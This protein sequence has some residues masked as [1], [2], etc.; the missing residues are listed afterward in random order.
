MA[1]IVTTSPL[2]VS[3]VAEKFGVTPQAVRK[4]ITQG[5]RGSYLKASRA[6]SSGMFYIEES[7]LEDFITSNKKPSNP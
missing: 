3:D 6:G 1:E 2:H 7:D 5:L 4:W